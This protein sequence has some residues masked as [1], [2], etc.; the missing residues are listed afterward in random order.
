MS[1]RG[2]CTTVDGSLW[3]SVLF[4]PCLSQDAPLLMWWSLGIRSTPAEA[5]SNL[6]HL[7]RTWCFLATLPFMGL[8]QGRPH[9]I[10]QGLR[11]WCLNPRDGETSCSPTS[12][13][14]WTSFPRSPTSGRLAMVNLKVEVPYCF[15]VMDTESP[16]EQWSPIFLAPV[17]SFMEE[18]S[19][20]D[21]G[22]ECFWDDSSTWHLLYTEF[23]LLLYQ[24]H[25]RSL[26]QEDALEKEMATHS[27]NLAWEIPW[28]GEPSGLQS[29]GLQRTRHSLRTKQQQHPPRDC[30]F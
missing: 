29:M 15:Q 20:R 16:R 11:G 23:L 4:T 24:L 19:F 13:E 9:R 7:L 8:H 12:W 14:H 10:H 17:T 30:S 3:G 2:I 27:S 21:Q 18:N 25:L 28:T 26:S 22:R 5:A 6:Q 1:A